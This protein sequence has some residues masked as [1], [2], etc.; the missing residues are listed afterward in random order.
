MVFEHPETSDNP[1]VKAR[2]LKLREIQ[3]K[4]HEHLVHAQA[5]YKEAAD[6]HRLE[7]DQINDVHLTPTRS[8]KAM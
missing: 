5:M 6:Q 7:S 1:A 8:M 4:V 2:L 3:T